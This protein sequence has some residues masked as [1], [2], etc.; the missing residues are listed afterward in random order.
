[1]KNFILIFGFLYILNPS[2]LYSQEEDIT[3]KFAYRSFSISPLGIFVGKNTGAAFSGDV[4]F[5]YGRNIISLEFGAGTEGKSYGNSNQY[6][7]VNLL[8]G[9]SFQL[10]EKIFSDLFV[11]AGYFK[12]RTYDFIG[13]TGRKG[14]SK[15]NTIGFPI[16][17]KFQYKL[18]SQYSMG[19]KVGAN[20][21]SVETIGIIGL[22]LQWNRERK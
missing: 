1:M 20:I 18:E 13:N 19:V 14:I 21:N 6:T 11:G 9:R 5:D 15:E 7:A 22:V 12:Y 16:G 17:A 10:S 3:N 4:S 2:L 8:Y